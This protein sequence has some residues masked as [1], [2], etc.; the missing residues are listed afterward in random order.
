MIANAKRQIEEKKAKLGLLNLDDKSEEVAAKRAKVAASLAS[1]HILKNGTNNKVLPTMGVTLPGG[2]VGTTAVGRPGGQP[3]EQMSAQERERYQNLIIDSEGRTVDK[4]T[5]EIVQIASRVP[6]L[7]ANLK[8]A[9]QQLR[10][11]L[12]KASTDLFASGLTSTISNATGILTSASANLQ[13]SLT[14]AA[15]STSAAV[16]QSEKFFDSRLK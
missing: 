11:R 5:G 15:A 6:T 9:Q 16:E 1:E 7:K 10:Q 2:T 13:A 12:D 3:V 4:R 14:A 8:V